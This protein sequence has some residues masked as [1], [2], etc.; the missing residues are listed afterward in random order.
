LWGGYS[1]TPLPR[2]HPLPER[3]YNIAILSHPPLKR[4]KLRVLLYQLI[5]FKVIVLGKVCMAR[6]EDY[7]QKD[8]CLIPELAEIRDALKEMGENQFHCMVVVR[9]ANHLVGIL[10]R[11]DIIKLRGSI[12]LKE[13]IV[14]DLI[15]GQALV[16][17][18]PRDY[19]A[20]A[21]SR[22]ERY[23]NIDQIVVVDALEPAGVLTKDDVLRWIYEEEFP[24]ALSG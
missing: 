14:R 6:V 24:N 8:F 16:F 12:L 10:T 13:G 7:M 2:Q 20:D 17:L 3:H 23:P 19:M 5:I 21:L 15:E 18:R 22:F 4:G 11:G 1:I 9:G